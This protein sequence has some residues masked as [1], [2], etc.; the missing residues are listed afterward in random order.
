MPLIIS[1]PGIKGAR[2]TDSFA[3]VMDI[4]PTILDLAGAQFPESFN[5]RS[6]QPMRG[7]SIRPLLE[8]SEPVVYGSEEY[9]GGE[10]GGGKWMRKGNHK[11]VMVPK[12]Y[13]KGTWELYDVTVDPGEVNDLSEEMPEL[14]EEL[15]KEWDSYAEEIGVVDP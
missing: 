6:I 11:A 14:L 8:N 10:M 15:K 3:Y 2:I 5:G 1:G 12:P 13:G 9:I 4:M 7:R